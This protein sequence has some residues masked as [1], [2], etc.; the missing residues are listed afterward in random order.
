MNRGA[1]LLISVLILSSIM[2]GAIIFG[3]QSFRNET[4]AAT[5]LLNKK[6]AEAAAT[7]CMEEAFYRLGNNPAYVGNEILAIGG[8]SCTI[9]P[10]VSGGGTWTIETEAAAFGLN[11][12]LR[13]VLSSRFPLTITSWESLAHY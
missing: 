7:S 10:I 1:A 6:A 11:G 3:S 9:R 4:D 8:T 5:A 2:L 12:R 13:V